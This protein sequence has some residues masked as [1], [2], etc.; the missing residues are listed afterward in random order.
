MPIRPAAAGLNATAW[1][2]FPNVERFR[3]TSSA[4]IVSSE[5]RMMKISCGKMPVRR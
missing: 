5:A 3:K 1:S 2:A 4:A